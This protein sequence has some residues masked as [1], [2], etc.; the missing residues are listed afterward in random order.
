[1]TRR[2]SGWHRPAAT[3]LGLLVVYFAFPDKVIWSNAAFLLSVL[4]MAIGTVVLAWAITGQVRR[5]LS[6]DADDLQALVAL[7]ALVLVLFAFG[8]Y[9]LERASPGQIDGLRTRVD[10]L[11]FT[12]ATMATVGYGDVHAVGQVARAIVSAQMIFNIVFVGALAAVLTGRV[13]MRASE[14]ALARQGSPTRG[15]VPGSGDSS[16]VDE[17]AQDPPLPTTPSSHPLP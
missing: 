13:R 9:T 8:F 5:H 3:L 11:Y 10:A 6:G 17:T 7:L 15:A 14:L 12:L 4:G 1:M 16:A 2:A